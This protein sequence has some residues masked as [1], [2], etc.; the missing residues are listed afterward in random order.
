MEFLLKLSER[1]REREERESEREMERAEDV[2]SS[3]RHVS[4]V[5]RR[6]LVKWVPHTFPKNEIA[7]DADCVQYA[8]IVSQHAPHRKGGTHEVTYEDTEIKW[9]HVHELYFRD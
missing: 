1:E 3:M 5:G 7:T 4:D 6:V 2:L 9:H 8:G